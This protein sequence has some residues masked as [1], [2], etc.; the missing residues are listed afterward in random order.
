MLVNNKVLADKFIIELIE[1][2]NK[3]NWRIEK[4]MVENIHY[5]ICFA[6][7]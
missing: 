4:V 2:F 7:D 1:I 5:L 3:H 6:K